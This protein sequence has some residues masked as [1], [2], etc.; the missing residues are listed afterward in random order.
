M[1][2][3]MAKGPPLQETPKQL[4]LD[5]AHMCLPPP[6]MYMHVHVF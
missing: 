3:S 6:H 5:T 1:Q 2:G 4:C